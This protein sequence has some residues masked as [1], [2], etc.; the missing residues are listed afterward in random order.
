MKV[1]GDKTFDIHEGCHKEANYR[2][3]DTHL[4]MLMV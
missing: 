3:F 1:V 4:L 2:L